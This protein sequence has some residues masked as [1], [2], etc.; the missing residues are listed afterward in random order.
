MLK[1][2]NYKKNEKKNKK[3]DFFNLMHYLYIERKKKNIENL[4]ILKFVCIFVSDGWSRPTQVGT[5]K[6]VRSFFHI[7]G[8]NF[9]KIRTFLRFPLP[10]Q[11]EPF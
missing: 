5:I 2:Q 4:V 3:L 1:R 8:K 9:L 6:K 7:Y 11:G 10:S